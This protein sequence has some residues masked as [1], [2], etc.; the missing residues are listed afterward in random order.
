MLVVTLRAPP[1]TAQRFSAAQRE[2][3]HPTPAQIGML[4]PPLH[5]QQDKQTFR[6]KTSV[7]VYYLDAFGMGEASSFHF[8][9]GS[10]VVNPGMHAAH[11]P[12]LRGES[13]LGEASRGFVPRAGVPFSPASVY[14]NNGLQMGKLRPT[15]VKD[16]LCTSKSQSFLAR[17]PGLELRIYLGRAMLCF[18]DQGPHLLG[19]CFESQLPCS[20]FLDV[21]Q[22]GASWLLASR[23]RSVLFA[24]AF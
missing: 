19:C 10:R 23:N 13:V 24:L 9:E 14:K 3:P 20:P 16:L 22:V 17:E 5:T 11:L 21:P 1:S 15:G 4:S 12:Q 8:P 6:A 2:L 18:L 7:E